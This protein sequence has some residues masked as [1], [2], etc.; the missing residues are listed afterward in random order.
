MAGVEAAF[1]MW[2]PVVGWAIKPS[3]INRKLRQRITMSWYTIK[4]G[5]GFTRYITISVM[6]M[7]TAA[8]ITARWSTI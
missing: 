7:I 6:A 8:I 4:L 3:T 1:E 5:Q 2:N